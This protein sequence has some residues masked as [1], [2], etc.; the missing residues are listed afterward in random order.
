MD[1]FAGAKAGYERA[2]AAQ[3]ER[4]V[5]DREVAVCLNNLG[6]ILAGMKDYAGALA[7]YR[8]A[9][10]IYEKTVGPDHPLVAGTLNNLGSLLER[11]D[12]PA[13]AVPLLRR[14]LEIA[15]KTYGPD[16][17]RTG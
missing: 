6:T 11:M 9:L 14:S 13:E 15:E 5:E 10:T 7:L 3:R 12:K 8:N 16:H 17:V 2:L 4:G 1:D